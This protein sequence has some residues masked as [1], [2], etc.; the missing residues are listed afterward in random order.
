M[1]VVIRSQEFFSGTFS[2]QVAFKLID[3]NLGSKVVV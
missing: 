3:L 1:D 2:Q